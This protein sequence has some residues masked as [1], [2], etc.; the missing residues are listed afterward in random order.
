[1]RRPRLQSLAR[2]CLVAL[3]AIASANIEAA[4]AE[5]IRERIEAIDAG[6]EISVAGT[7][8]QAQRSLAKLYA[9]NGYQ[10]YWDATR[11]QSLLEVID[12]VE[13][14]GLRPTDYHLESLRRL[15]AVRASSDFERAQLDLLASDSF[16]LI[17]FHLYFGKVDPVSLD[18]NW[19]FD[20]REIR[21][22]D[23]VRFVHDAI[24]GNRI[25]NGVA[26]ARPDHW[27]YAAGRDALAQHRSIA[28]LGGWPTIPDGVTLALG[29]RDPR[30]PLLRRRLA[31]SGDLAVAGGESKLPAG[32]D[33]ELFDRQLE[34]ALRHA[35]RRHRLAVDG[36]LGPSTL[37]ALNLPVERRIAQLRVNLE[38][39]RQVLHEIRDGDLVVVD[40]AGFEVHYVRDRKR[41]WQS[42]AV[43]G[44]PYRETPVFKSAIDNIVL[45]PS[46]TVPPG[47]LEKD[48]LPAL[49]R[50]DR[51]VLARK[52]LKVLDRNGQPLDP[53]T[54]DFAR[55]TVRNFPYTL[56]QDPGPANALGVVKINFPNRH[57]VY[58]H[59]TPTK[60]LFGE[61]ERA[62]SSGCIRTERPL[63]LVQLL[64]AEPARWSRAALDEAIA[65]G[66]T[67]MLRLPRPVPVL[68][69]YWTADRDDDGSIVFKPDP[70]GRDARELAALDRGFPVDT[71]RRANRPL[72]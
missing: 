60:S 58:L 33:A 11:L 39:G 15:V 71:A 3:L 31:I 16:A 30:V 62:F 40:I 29:S 22:T 35:Q 36:L 4:V 21:D 27:M 18:P 52:N 42:R 17:L 28:A 65:S 8:L 38:R 66:E 23:V 44:Q 7:R 19:N 32:E 41:I 45:N 13:D 24:R 72:P 20:A 10:P 69:I 14:D 43:V 70:Y 63:E 57:L 5:V 64:L 49:R 55:Y 61:T 37:R 68:L 59:D 26:N 12:D 51:S 53:A 2:L 6:N 9:L 1:M 48:I 50:G 67:R 47:I 25:R 46:W 56:R 54:L 34:N